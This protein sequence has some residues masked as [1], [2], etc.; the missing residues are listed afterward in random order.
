MSQRERLKKRYPYA[1][2]LLLALAG[3]LA[4]GGDASG[5]MLLGGCRAAGLA[6][7]AAAIVLG[8]AAMA[9]T[10]N[11]AVSDQ[12]ARGNSR[13]L[14]WILAALLVL[15]GSIALHQLRSHDNDRAPNGHFSESDPRRIDCYTF[16]LDAAKKLI[17]GVNPF[18]TTQV[19]IY[20]ADHTKQF[21]GPGWVV[22]GRVQLGI[23]YPPVTF[24]SAVPGY[25]MGDV[26]YG[27]LAAVLLAAI[28]AFAVVPNVPGLC[29]AAFLLLNPI[30]FMVEDRCW[31]E[32]VAWMFLCA[33]VYAAVKRPRWLALALGLFLASKQFDLLA[34]P[35]IG[36]LLRPFAWKAYWRLLGSSVAVAVATLLPFAFP[37][38][39]ALWHDLVLFHIAQP[40]RPDAL[41][42]GVVFP[43]YMKVGLL[44]LL[45]FL[46]W[47]ARRGTDRTALFP[48][49]FGMALLLFVSAGKQAFMNYYFLIGESLLLAAAMLWPASTADDA[50]ITEGKERAD[51]SLQECTHI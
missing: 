29:L 10:V 11:G 9:M 25:F 35:T 51:R 2:A 19:D 37:H 32:P 36:I 28:F 48:A 39:G 30:T 5:D 44:P 24:L 50:P 15:H 42:F 18:G 7:L 46:A 49:A 6:L 23:Q 17:H 27:F 21:Y 16:E 13:H 20:D 40:F 41:S 8:I 43:P 47:I 12:A 33:T 34:L 14:W 26:R 3:L 1:G 31:T 45:A 4:L 22:N 38:P